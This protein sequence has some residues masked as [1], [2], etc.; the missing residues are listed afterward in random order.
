MRGPSDL[1]SLVHGYAPEGDAISHDLAVS[2]VGSGRNMW[3]RSEFDPGHFTASAFVVSPDRSSLLLIHHRKLDRWLQPGG[4]IEP[5]DETIED[6][7]R[8]EV[9][10]ETGV[11]D[12][13]RLGT[14]LARIDVHEIPRRGSEPTHVHL[15]LGLGFLATTTE[16][17]PI[18]EVLEARWVLFEDLESF[19]ADDAL[20]AGARVARRI[21]G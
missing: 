15:D 21:S 6:A 20:L 10:E 12:L 4:H 3:L 9:E 2:V 7:A 1:E 19:G 5:L 18:D 13:V 8:R 11:I 14:S 16:I 17:G